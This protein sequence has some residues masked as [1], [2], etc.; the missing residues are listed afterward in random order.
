MS[1][2]EQSKKKN[3]F[4]LR[5]DET[6]LQDKLYFTYAL[7]DEYRMGNKVVVKILEKSSLIYVIYTYITHTQKRMYF[8][9]YST[10]NKRIYCLGLAR[11]IN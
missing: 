3:R 4:Y 6:I 5:Y 7:S 10:F 9:I 8:S 11:C 1:L 2:I